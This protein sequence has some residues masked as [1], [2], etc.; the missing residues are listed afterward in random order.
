MDSALPREARPVN[1]LLDWGLPQWKEHTSNSAVKFGLEW[2]RTHRV[3]P[4]IQEYDDSIVA[5]LSEGENGEEECTVLVRVAEDGGA[6]VEHQGGDEPTDEVRWGAA[7][8]AVLAWQTRHPASQAQIHSMAD[9]VRAERKMR[10]KHGVAVTSAEEGG[11][12]LWYAQSID[13]GKGPHKEAWQVHLRATDLPINGCTCPDFQNNGLGTCKH[14][15]AVLHAPSSPREGHHPDIVPYLRTDDAL[16]PGLQVPLRHRAWYEAHLHAQ[17]PEGDVRLADGPGGCMRLEWPPDALESW[18]DWWM[19]WDGQGPV[20]IGP[21]LRARVERQAA[22]RLERARRAQRTAELAHLSDRPAFL[23]L[24]EGRLFPYQ[25]EGVRHLAG[26]GCALLADDMGLGKTLQAIAAMMWLRERGDVRHTLVVVPVALLHQWKKEILDFTTLV[27]KEEDVVVLDASVRQPE[28]LIR[29]RPKVL[30]V[31]YEKMKSLLGPL[32]EHFAPDLV[33]ADE[34]QKF[35]NWE[36]QIARYVKA[37]KAPFRFALTGTPLENNLLEYFSILQFVD[38]DVLGPMWRFVVE[39]HI[40]SDKGHVIQTR[41]VSALHKRTAD[42][43]LRRGRAFVADSLPARQEIRM[44]VSLDARQRDLHDPL[45]QQIHKLGAI[46]RIRPLSPQEGS[47][48]KGLIQR[49]RMVCD[50]AGLLDHSV[51]TS[52]KLTL[53][54]ELVSQLVETQK[55][56]VVVFSA[57][58]RMGKLAVDHLTRAGIRAEQYHGQ[59]DARIRRKVLER[60]KEDEQ[61]QVVVFTDS[62][63]TGLNLQF[64]SALIHLDMPWNPAVWEQRSAR[65][66]RLGQRSD[67]LIYTLLAEDSYELHVEDTVRNK[68]ALFDFAVEGVPAEEL[69]QPDD[70]L[71]ASANPVGLDALMIEVM[72]GTGRLPPDGTDPVD[73]RPEAP[74]DDEGDDAVPPPPAQEM[75][76]KPRPARPTARPRPQQHLDDQHAALRQVP[77]TV[78]PLLQAFWKSG[79]RRIAVKELLRGETLRACAVLGDPMPEGWDAIAAWWVD[80]AGATGVVPAER[81]QAMGC[82]SLLCTLPNDL[83]EEA[84]EPDLWYQLLGG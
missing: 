61:L 25:V 74:A 4:V 12:G 63:A 52:P 38:P 47:L 68:R 46:A 42:V 34:A 27:P 72:E 48:L 10:G 36:S 58:I 41:N 44:T 76:A 30:I 31:G 37:L 83:C 60:F 56:K 5:T 70:E 82:A 8:A 51:E 53:M 2:F 20:S 21:D 71:A 39:Y 62:G 50:S 67:V 40:L 19:Q 54:T 80:R 15:E 49:A 65:I 77:L 75:E 7:I 26:R 32:N 28:Q 57:W 29:S 16:V 14:L 66:A 17:L 79:R 1:K 45:V 35:K 24:G 22:R 78:R 43:V 33:I 84:L 55:R 6:T 11:W 69:D 18:L 73:L 23:T 9:R 59:L 3:E 81:A 64:A 13:D